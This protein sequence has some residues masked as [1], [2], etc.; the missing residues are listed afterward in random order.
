MT[1]VLSATLVLFLAL[2]GKHLMQL[3]ATWQHSDDRQA[4]SV[5]LPEL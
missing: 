2:A 4:R 5:Q 3:L 1:D